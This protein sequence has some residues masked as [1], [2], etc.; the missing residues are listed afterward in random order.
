M[1][2]MRT[3]SLN[4][5]DAVQGGLLSDADII[6]D[7]ALFTL[8]DYN[9]TQA[10]SPALRVQFKDGDD[11]LHEQHYSAGKSEN[12]VPSEDGRKLL[13]T[14]TA[15]ALNTG[16]NVY[17]FLKSLVD[18]GFPIEKLMDDIGVIVGTRA[19]VI[20]VANPAE[21]GEQKLDKNG[22]PKTTLLVTKILALPGEKVAKAKAAAPKVAVTAGKPATTVT[23]AGTLTAPASDDTVSKTVGYVI[24]ALQAAG[25]PISRQ[26]ISQKVF[27]IANSAKDADK[28]GVCKLAF[29][30]G[31][32][33]GNSGSPI[34]AGEDL[35]AFE[36]DAETKM[37]KLAVLTT[38]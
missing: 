2:E 34:Q 5:N 13:L 7:S 18:S 27:M 25:G 32:L 35:V 14:G 28:A 24:T 29:E 16:S 21:R 3:A 23:P 30:E 12:F 20:Q 10:P 19:H 6:I 17:K 8:F 38:A 22:R 11:K 1:S 31:F 15:T 9:G 36:Y 26:A 37:I 33:S 4:P